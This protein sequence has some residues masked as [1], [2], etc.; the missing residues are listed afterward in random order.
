MCIAYV[1]S[2]ANAQCPTEKKKMH[3]GR[4]KCHVQTDE[5]GKRRV[6]ELL[7]S[8]YMN[9]RPQQAAVFNQDIWGMEREKM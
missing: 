7:A 2:G 4:W 5:K 1:S 9:S 6:A 3:C 8:D